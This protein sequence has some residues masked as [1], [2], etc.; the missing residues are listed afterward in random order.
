MS[1]GGGLVS[2]VLAPSRRLVTARHPL[3]HTIGA[4]LETGLCVVSLAPGAR[5][6]NSVRRGRRRTERGWELHGLNQISRTETVT[7]AAII[8]GLSRIVLIC[9]RASS[10]SINSIRQRVCVST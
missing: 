1:F 10:V 2:G 3:S 4:W 7:E 9:R 8:N 5:W 6:R